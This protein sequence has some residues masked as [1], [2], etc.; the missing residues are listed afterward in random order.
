MPDGNNE[1]DQQQSGGG[2]GGQ[3]SDTVSRQ[4]LNDVIRER[5]K[6]KAKAQAYKDQAAAAEAEV[7][8]LSGELDQANAE[9]RMTV[10]PEGVEGAKRAILSASAS[11]Q[12]AYSGNQVASILAER[13]IAEVTDDGQI[14]LSFIDPTSGETILDDSGEPLR[15]P[16]GIV[17][18]LLSEPD[19][20]N[21][22]R[23]DRREQYVQERQ[24]REQIASHL[25]APPKTMD[26]LKKLPQRVRDAVVN[27]MTPEQRAAMAAPAT[28]R[29]FL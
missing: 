3:Q 13:T 21:L 14:V 9:G 18:D 4:H 10:T 27:G 22:I 28:S 17:R 23:Q 26:E 15:D 2:G 19:N 25:V 7:Q 20:A 16:G 8:R 11:E 1:D 5:Q 24:V 12:G 29:N 6:A